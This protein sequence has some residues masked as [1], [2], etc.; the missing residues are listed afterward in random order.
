ML[1]PN[2]KIQIDFVHDTS[3]GET[4]LE[5][6]SGGSVHVDGFT[7]DE[8]DRW[9]DNFDT[10]ISILRDRLYDGMVD[11]QTVQH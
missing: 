7:N 8:L 10:L 1:T 11:S 3:Y 9:L 2:I 4:N 6:A 5:V